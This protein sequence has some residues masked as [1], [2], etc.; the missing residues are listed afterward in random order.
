MTYQWCKNVV[1]LRT[2]RGI[3]YT[4]RTEVRSEIPIHVQHDTK[5]NR[6]SKIRRVL[7]RNMFSTGFNKLRRGVFAGDIVTKER[8]WPEAIPSASGSIYSECERLPQHHSHPIPLVRTDQLFMFKHSLKTCITAVAC[9]CWPEKDDCGYFLTSKIIQLRAV[10]GEWHSLVPTVWLIA[11]SLPYMYG[12]WMGN[13]Y[14]EAK[15]RY[16][17]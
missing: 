13:T 7:L 2:T 12:V 15:N 1:T 14:I 16:S 6:V 11:K 5:S 9:N 17:C 8:V 10:W 4:D 3:T